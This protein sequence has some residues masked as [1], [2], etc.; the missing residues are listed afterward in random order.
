[1]DSEIKDEDVLNEFETEV[2]TLSIFEQIQLAFLITILITFSP[3]LLPI[4]LLTKNHN[5]CPTR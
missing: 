4:H 1:M 2:V 5:P 3:V